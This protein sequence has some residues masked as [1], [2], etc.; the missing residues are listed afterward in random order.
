MTLRTL[1][2][3]P[4]AAPGGQ[5]TIRINYGRNSWMERDLLR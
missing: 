5:L 2:Y 3:D 1:Q 4:A